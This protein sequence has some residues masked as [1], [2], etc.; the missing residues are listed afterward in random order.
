[1]GLVQY[2]PNIKTLILYNYHVQWMHQIKHI[3]LKKILRQY[4]IT[5]LTQQDF[6]MNCFRFTRKKA[7]TKKYCWSHTLGAHTRTKLYLLDAACD[8]SSLCVCVCEPH[9]ANIHRYHHIVVAFAW[10]AA[11]H[12]HFAKGTTA[13]CV[14]AASRCSGSG[15]GKKHSETQRRRLSLCVCVCALRAYDV[16][17]LSISNIFLMCRRATGRVN[18]REVPK[19][20]NGG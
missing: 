20:K 13:A 11:Y 7:F 14:R 1:M 16:F 2:D 12:E 9:I 4:S 15:K 8:E 5:I 18:M 3:A 6:I 17:A 19:K 10:R